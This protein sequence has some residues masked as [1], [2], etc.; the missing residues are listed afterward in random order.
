MNITIP[1]NA[2]TKAAG[3]ILREIQVQVLVPD[4]LP[5]YPHRRVSTIVRVIFIARVI[6]IV[7]IILIVPGLLDQFRV[8]RIA[9][10]SLITG[11]SLSSGVSSSF[12]GSP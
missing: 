10:V 6:L 8:I 4:I 1:R 11:L 3:R 2:V 7:R 12:R 9:G 5:G